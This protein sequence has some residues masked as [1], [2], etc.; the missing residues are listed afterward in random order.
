MS[1]HYYK[2][3]IDSPTGKR[4]TQFWHRC[5]KC[6]QEADNYAKKMGGQYYYSDPKYFAGGVVYIS[7]PNNKPSDPKMWREV[8]CQY[9][10]G[11]FVPAKSPDYKGPSSTADVVYY[12]P[13]VTK[14]L[15]W[16]EVPTK[17]YRPQDTFDSIYSTAAPVEKPDKDGKLHYWLQ[18]VRFEYDEEPGPSSSGLRV[19][20][21]SVR[22][23]I[24]AEMKR[25][26]LPVMRVEPLLS[27]LGAVMPEPEDGKR[28]KS[29]DNTPTFFAYQY[30]YLIGCDYECQ[31]DGME[32][33][34]PQQH[35]TYVCKFQNE[36]KNKGN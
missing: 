15:E 33:L 19:A 31:A 17:D 3:L 10:D 32:E 8:G 14:R 29:I 22:R 4:L 36:Q 23:A 28:S 9:E 35:H 26:K 6:E 5:M 24:K 12:E 18:V 11:T 20:S 16:V 21:R 7:F 27:L 30:N 13:N 2:V 34:T 1:K 25:S